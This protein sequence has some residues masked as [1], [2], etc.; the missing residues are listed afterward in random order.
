M[1]SLEPW[2]EPDTVK[3]LTVVCGD[4]NHTVYG[5]RLYHVLAVPT[6]LSPFVS[7]VQ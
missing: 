2:F 5:F 6:C 4:V 1:F 7:M 3:H